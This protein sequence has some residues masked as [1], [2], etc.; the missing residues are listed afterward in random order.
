MSG[1]VRKLVAAAVIVAMASG[2][3]G[4]ATAAAQDPDAPSIAEVAT[5]DGRFT[6]LVTALELAGL[7]EMFSTC[8]GGE[9]T[10]LAP[11]DDAF[12]STLEALG[13]EATDLAADTELLTSVL[14]YHVIE[15]AVASDAVVGLDGSSATTVN[16]E[17][18]SISVDGDTIS[19]GSGNPT[20][21]N[22]V[23]ADVQACNGI[24][25]AIDS[26]LIPP[27]VAASLGV[28]QEEPTD[29]EP[30]DEEPTDEEPTD[31]EPTD[32]LA[33]TGA[34]SDVLAVVAAALLAAGVLVVATSRRLRTLR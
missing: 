31:E 21:A 6:T 18:I 16:G 4:A 29:E 32:E 3:A 15:G 7:A 8:D 2:V 11:T 1:G 17:D 24:V 12:T 20:A 23:V 9:Y 26:V 25:H 22:V 10:V 34:A 28:A 14:T 5:A 33:T 19:I 27:T 13:L 30:T